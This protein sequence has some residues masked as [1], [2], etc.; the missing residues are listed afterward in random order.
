MILSPILD[1][2]SLGTCMMPSL[3][4]A[5]APFLPIFSISPLI[6]LFANISKGD[7]LL[8]ILPL[9]RQI[10]KS[11]SLITS[12]LS[13]L[14]RNVVIFKFLIMFDNSSCSLERIE[15]SS[16]LNG[17]SKIKNQVLLLKLLLVLLFELLLLI[18]ERFFYSLMN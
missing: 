1:A 10:I 7:P 2:F 13:W 17:S 9:F 14:T 16:A 8:L 5:K 3:I 11:Q 15:K 4:R 6:C 12:L 18:G